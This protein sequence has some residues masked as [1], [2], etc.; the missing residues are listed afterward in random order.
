MFVP[1]P[2]ARLIGL[3]AFALVVGQPLVYAALGVGWL[4]AAAAD[5]PP[6]DPIYLGLLVF[7]IVM[8]VCLLV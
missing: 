3:A 7:E 4:G 1:H 5:R 8:G 2:V 6:L